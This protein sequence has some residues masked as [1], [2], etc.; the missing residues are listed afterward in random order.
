MHAPMH[1]AI[2]GHVIK[3]PWHRLDRQ[4]REQPRILLEASECSVPGVR[5]ALGLRVEGSGFRVQGLGFRVQGV[6]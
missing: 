5:V 1:W 2:L 3:S 4:L 6:G